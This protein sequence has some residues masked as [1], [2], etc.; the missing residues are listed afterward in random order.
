MAVQY[1][2]RM[3]GACSYTLCHLVIKLSE[4]YLVWKITHHAEHL[5]SS[6]NTRADFESRHHSDSS[7]WRLH[8]Q[9]HIQC[10]EPT[11]WSFLN[12]S[13]CFFS[14][15]SPNALFSWKL[16]PQAAGVDTRSQTWSKLHPH[17]FPLFALVGRCL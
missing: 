8:C 2:N 14:E 13:V 9:V 3:E 4:R 5:P 10:T 16:N 12:R 1:I 15:H 7:N 17:A 6:L 11:V